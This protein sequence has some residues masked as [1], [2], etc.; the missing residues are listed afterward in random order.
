M[1]KDSKGQGKMEDSG[2]GLLSAVEG[3]SLEYNR[4]VS[5]L[6][7]DR[8]NGAD[9]QTANLMVRISMR[10]V[11]GIEHHDNLSQP[12]ASNAH[13]SLYHQ[14]FLTF[15]VFLI[16]FYLL[17]LR[18]RERGEGGRGERERHRQTDR[19]TDR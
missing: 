12:A 6:S 14:V 4:I 5:S 13:E 16:P 2:G 10:V 18:E 15:Q 17:S 8:K 1:D 19:Q 11:G 3:H 9:F 7:Y